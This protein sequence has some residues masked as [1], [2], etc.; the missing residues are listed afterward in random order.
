MTKANRTE[1]S[2]IMLIGTFLGLVETANNERKTQFL[3]D[4][5]VEVEE[6]G[7]TYKVPVRGFGDN[8]IGAD[9]L[10]NQPVVV[11]ARYALEFGQDKQT[12]YGNLE[13][14]SIRPGPD[15]VTRNTFAQTGT[16]ITTEEKGKIKVLTLEVLGN[17]WNSDKRVREPVERQLSIAFMGENKELLEGVQPGDSVMVEGTVRSS[18]EKNYLDFVA[19]DLTLLAGDSSTDPAGTDDL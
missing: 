12:V 6:N 11:D 15:D 8:I 2:Q 9:S 14:V 13:V 5:F 19:T 16:V 10:I 3:K 4:T 1:L 17:A 18:G 7:K